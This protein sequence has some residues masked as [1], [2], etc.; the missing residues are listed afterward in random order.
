MKAEEI[1]EL[2]TNILAD[3]S[4]LESAVVEVPKRQSDEWWEDLVEDVP[5]LPVAAGNYLMVADDNNL[6][7][8]SDVVFIKNDLSVLK[9][10]KID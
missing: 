9:F 3:A 10:I 1:I 7:K 4:V 6:F 5:V 8:K 2:F